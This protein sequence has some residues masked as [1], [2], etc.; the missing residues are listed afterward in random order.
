METRGYRRGTFPGY[1]IVHLV[2]RSIMMRTP[3]AINED[4]LRLSDGA[5]GKVR[6]KSNVDCGMWGATVRLTPDWLS[7][8]NADEAVANLRNYRVNTGT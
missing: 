7:G 2:L 1:S 4:N 6:V 8:I 5:F 3:R